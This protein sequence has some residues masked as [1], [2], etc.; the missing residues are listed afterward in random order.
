M[1]GAGAVLEG[2]ILSTVIVGLVAGVLAKF[3]LPGKDPGGILVTILV[4]IAGAL[5][6]GFVARAAQIPIT[7][8]AAQVG[9]AAIGAVVLLLG[10]RLTMAR[11]TR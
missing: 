7:G 9:A 6:A 8:I 2:S 5:L 1:T 4:G 10:Y 11:R 3:V